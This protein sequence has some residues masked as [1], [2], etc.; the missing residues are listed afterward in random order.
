MLHSCCCLPGADP[1]PLTSAP[2]ALY[3]NVI[4]K[5]LD[6]CALPDSIRPEG[7]DVNIAKKFEQIGDD[8]ADKVL[9]SI[10][11]GLE[12]TER[13]AIVVL[14]LN[15]DVGNFF[16]A[17]QKARSKFSGLSL[18][19]VGTCYTQM[20][21]EW[22][23]KAWLDQLSQQFASGE[24]IIPGFTPK[25]LVTP[26]HILEEAPPKP[27]LSLMTWMGDEEGM[28]GKPRGVKVPPALLTQWYQHQ[29]FGDQFRTFCDVVIVECGSEDAGGNVN[30][31]PKKRKAD[32][33]L[34]PILSP[35]NKL[36]KQVVPLFENTT[37]TDPIL[38]TV[39]M[40]SIKA[41]TPLALKVRGLLTFQY[42]DTG[43]RLHS[44]TCF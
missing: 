24:L 43:A 26:T 9:C 14:D 44:Y 23:E 33:A 32:E 37:I 3:R 35:N 29:I 10:L 42:H 12:C 17:F 11:D 25:S 2:F 21:Q 7:A 41:A 8:A 30:A 31:T 38:A 40:L 39:P 20:H 6:P 22:F 34:L 1:C 27:A 18:H 15:P 16:S 4:L 36:A 19:Y 5:D 13:L 28:A